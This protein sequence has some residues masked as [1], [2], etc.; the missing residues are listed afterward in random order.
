MPPADEDQSPRLRPGQALPATVPAG[1]NDSSSRANII[2]LTPPV[3]DIQEHPNSDAAQQNVNELHPW[4][5]HRAAKDV[6]VG[7][8]YFKRQNYRGAESRY[9]DALIYKPD[10]AVSTFRLGQICDKTGRISEAVFFYKN[11]L[12]ILPRG[13]YAGDAQNAITKLEAQ[14]NPP[15]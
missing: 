15:K 10:D 3:G 7:D 13:P 4:D 1:P 6:E 11:Y 14:L 12:K 5:P 8:Y 2:D 9:R